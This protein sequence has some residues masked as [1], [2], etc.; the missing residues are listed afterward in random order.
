MESPLDGAVVTV[1]DRD[2]GRSQDIQLRT[3]THTQE[4]PAGKYGFVAKLQARSSTAVD[5]ALHV[6]E[7]L[8]VKLTVI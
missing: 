2:T 4:L 7:T 5:V 6:G 8:D 3:N 1:T